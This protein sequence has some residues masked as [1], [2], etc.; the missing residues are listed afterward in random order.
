MKEKIN[1]SGFAD[2]ISS[3]FDVQLKTV[4]ALGMDYISL[5]SADGLGIADYSVLEVEQKLLPKLKEHQV[6]VSSIGSPIGKVGI[7]DEEGFQKQIEQLENICQ[8]CKILDCRYIRIFSF[9]MPKGKNPKEYR[10]AVMEKLKVFISIAKKHEVVLIHENEKEIYGDTAERCLDLMETLGN[11]HFKSVFDF[12]N[13]VQCNEH[14]EM[15]FDML[16]PYVAYIH[17][18]DAVSDDNENVVCGTGEGRIK[19]ILTRAICE[20]NYEG[21]LTLEPHLV[22]FDALA[23]LETTD[24]ENI[25]KENKAKDGAQGYTMQYQALCEILATI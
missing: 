2:E 17:I 9:Y 3:E 15:C 11:D 19:E 21:F 18:K 13:F 12:A 4:K 16:K 25:I 22:L 8:M 5:R 23:S 10:E 1:I 7:L 20:E 6:S 24:A 14:P